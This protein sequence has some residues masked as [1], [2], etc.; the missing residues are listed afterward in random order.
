MT[1]FNSGLYRHP[2]QWPPGAC[3]AWRWPGPSGTGSPPSW[4]PTA[5]WSL[6]SAPQCLRGG[7]LQLFSDSLEWNFSFPK[8][9]CSSLVL[10]GERF[11]PLSHAAGKLRIVRKSST[12]LNTSQTKSF[13][14]G[15]KI[16][17]LSIPQGPLNTAP[18][19]TGV[20]IKCNSI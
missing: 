6:A 11:P 18:L 3:E 17:A 16:L 20:H 14:L 12:P 4:S 10:A 15:R 9:N 19:P 1:L 2:D 8:L 5:W 13:R 7:S